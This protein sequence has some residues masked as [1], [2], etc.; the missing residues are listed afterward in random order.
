MY[1][2]DGKPMKVYKVTFEHIP[3]GILQ[4]VFVESIGSNEAGQSVLANLGEEYDLLMSI[5]VK[6]RDLNWKFYN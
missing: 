4:T 2:K 1:T 6:P 5:Y 3:T